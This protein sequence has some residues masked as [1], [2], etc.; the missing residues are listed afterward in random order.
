VTDVVYNGDVTGH[1]VLAISIY[2]LESTDPVTP[3]RWYQR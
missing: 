1:F 3:I 2:K